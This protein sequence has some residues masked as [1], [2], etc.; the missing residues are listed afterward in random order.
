MSFYTALTGLNAASAQLGVSSNNIANVG[1]IGFKKSRAQFGDIFAT[2]PL[3]KNSSVVGQG[4]N[5]KEISQ[6]FTQGN[7]VNSANSLDLA[8]SGQGFFALKPNLTSNQTVYTRN[9]GFSVNND[10]YVVDSVGQFLQVFP[11]NEDGSVTSTSIDAAGSLQLPETSG[12]PKASSQLLLGVNLP[13]DAEIIPKRDIF[14]S[15]QANYEFDRNDPET[16]NK[17]TSITVF[18]SLGNASIATIYYYKTQNA[19]VDDPT[20]KWQTRIFIGDREIEPALLKAKND[21]NEVL[22]INKFGQLSADPAAVDPTFNPNAAHPKYALDDQ[23]TQVPSQSGSWTGGFMQNGADFGSTD[24]VPITVTGDSPD[25][26]ATSATD[27]LSGQDLFRVSI[28][29]SNYVDVS[30][31]INA[32]DTQ[33]LNGSGL[34]NAISLALNDQFGDERFFD[35]SNA[36]DRA[37]RITTVDENGVETP[38]VVQIDIP[39]GKTATTMLPSDIVDAIKA[40]MDTIDLGDGTG[41]SLG[42][43]LAVS[44][45]IRERAIQF[46]PSSSEFDDDISQIRVTGWDAATASATENLV[47]GFGATSETIAVGAS[48][49]LGA[50]LSDALVPNGDFRLDP[51]QQRSGIDVEYLRDERRFVFYSGTTGEAST[52]EIEPLYRFFQDGDAAGQPTGE[53]VPLEQVE[54]ALAAGTAAL[55][56]VRAGQVLG[57]AEEVADEILVRAGTGLPGVPAITTGSRSGVD[58]SGTFP[59][60][61][62]DNVISVTVDGV[63]GKITIPPGAYTGDTFAAEVE[64]RVNLIETEDGRKVSGVKVRFDIDAQRFTFT[65]GTASRDSFINVNGHPN[66]GLAVTTQSRGDVPDVTILQQA[67]DEDGNPIFVDGDGNETIVPIDGTPNWVPV[68]LD[69]GE[70]TFDTSGRLISPKEGAAYTPFDPQNGSDPIVLNVDYGT[71]STQFSQPFSVLSL[72]QDGFPSGKLDGLD[73]DSSGVVRANYTNGQQVALGKIILTNFANPNGLKQ[74]GDA[75][76]LETTNSGQPTLGE[77]GGDGF[78]SIQAGALERANVDLTEEL[79]ELITAQRNFQANAKAIETSSTLTQTI[80]NIR[81]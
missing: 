51:D 59:V 69:K 72:S 29:G 61:F 6:V 11:V 3:Q 43:R 66:F 13:A 18:D 57:F 73:I 21:K 16:Y 9:G 24:L 23:K 58:T 17:S 64:K 70:L 63:D 35:F 27:P 53:V 62:Q 8:V 52:I 34:A 40:Q 44:Y 36:T 45:N 49:T 65:S 42:D 15:G 50:F 67:R 30:L 38:H 22:Y 19:T 20:N 37:F 32:G 56:N 76:Y 68:Y 1:T 78:G 28:D 46:K 14:T 71:N 60:T 5:L 74:I 2:S 80:I 39:D 54:A 26:A 31:P 7:I 41:D 75:N 33:A 48:V 10:R 12:E 55:A 81:N 79:V 4:V 47:L 77:A 25:N